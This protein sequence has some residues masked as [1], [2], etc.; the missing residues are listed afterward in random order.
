MM[1]PQGK[2]LPCTLE[3]AALFVNAIVHG[4]SNRH[5]PCPN[6]SGVHLP[7]RYRIS[8]N[9]G[10]PTAAVMHLTQ[11]FL[12]SRMVNSSQAVG[13]FLRECIGGLRGHNPAGSS[14]WRASAGW[15]VKLVLMKR[16]AIRLGCPTTAA[17]SLVISL[18]EACPDPW[19]VLS[20]S[21]DRRGSGSCT[22]PSQSLQRGF[23]WHP[24]NLHPV[25]L[26]QLML[27]VSDTVLQLTVA[28]QYQQ[29]FT[30]GI[31]PPGGIIV[32][33]RDI[34]G[35]HRMHTITAELADD[36]KRFVEQ[37]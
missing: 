10:K 8:R 19:P 32:G 23:N 34:I 37:K 29:L 6:L 27:R 14:I 22:P 4:S 20:L 9:V 15:V 1:T 18:V 11:Q 17:K 24:F 36:S 33:K 31:Q 28:G 2:V 5:S 25:Y 21:K 26:G 16:L 12:P 13:M 7:T 35:Q 30:A 3:A